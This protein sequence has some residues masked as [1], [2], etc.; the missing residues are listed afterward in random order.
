MA[1]AGGDDV[2]R[3]ALKLEL[4]QINELDIEFVGEQ[5]RGAAS[6]SSEQAPILM[7]ILDGADEDGWRRQLRVCNPD[8][9]YGSVVALVKDPSAPA[10][11][12]ALRAGA[13]DVLG[14]PP[15]AEQA[16]HT[17]LRMSELSH[18]ERGNS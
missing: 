17:L 2:Q 9:R 5:A 15:P 4:S 16:F 1:L 13:D 18:R 10:V 12:A 6:K 14:M 11:R 7:V 8:G 3:T